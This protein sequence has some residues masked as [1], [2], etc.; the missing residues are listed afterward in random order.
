MV[1]AGTSLLTGGT[2]ELDRDMIGD[3][4]KQI[5]LL[6][7]EGLEMLLVTSG[8]VAAGKGVYLRPVSYT[9]LTLPTTPY[10]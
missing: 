2:D 6:H 4:V 5:S 7:S 10:V 8:A 3:I 9:H 1:K